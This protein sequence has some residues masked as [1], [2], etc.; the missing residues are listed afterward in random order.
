MSVG[1]QPRER[2]SA[3]RD[4]L[5]EC[6]MLLLP[7]SKTDK[8]LRFSWVL[9]CRA[10]N[11]DGPV[12]F[13]MRIARPPR[14][15]SARD[16]PRPAKSRSRLCLT[17][18][19]WDRPVLGM[20][21]PRLVRPRPSTS[22]KDQLGNSDGACSE[23][24]FPSLFSNNVGAASLADP[25]FM[26]S[27]SVDIDPTAHAKSLFGGI[28]IL[29]ISDGELAIED[30][31]GGEAVVDGHELPELDDR[32]VRPTHIAIGIEHSFLNP[33]LSGEI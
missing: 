12:L 3:V 28:L 4:A 24:N 17:G 6:S 31:M 25:D 8:Q 33:T 26:Q 9:A 32:K 14:M 30:E 2:V 20:R 7:P 16:R 23:C 10:F 29:G 22:D 1:F 21:V 11:M 13:P 27:T 15:D 5:L 19:G 18:L